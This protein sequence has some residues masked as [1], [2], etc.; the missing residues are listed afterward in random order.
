MGKRDRRISDCSNK[1]AFSRV[2]GVDLYNQ[3]IT[4]CVTKSF[5]SSATDSDHI[6]CVIIE[7]GGN[8]D[9]SRSNSING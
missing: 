4:G 5:T 2:I 7:I 6:P 8:D 1:E 3:S 9:E